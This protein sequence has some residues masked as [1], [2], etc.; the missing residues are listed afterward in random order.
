M[1]P[2]PKS[3]TMR[4]YV[5]LS[6]VEDESNSDARYDR[7]FVRNEI[8]PRLETRFPAYRETLTRAARNLADYARV[9]EAMA[10]IDAGQTNNGAIPVDRLRSLPDARALNLLRHLF[11][12]QHLAMPPRVRLEEALRQCRE[13][14]QDAG[15]SGGI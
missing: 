1:F 14:A 7:N 12:S 8:L 15:V 4:R 2:G 10:R 3:G 9:A 13:A 5:R 6:W 11:D